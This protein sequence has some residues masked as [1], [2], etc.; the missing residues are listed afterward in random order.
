ITGTS[1]QTVSYGDSGTAVTAVPETGY[2]FAG[3][4]DGSTVNPR[5]DTNV[6]GN[7]TVTA[8]FAI[9]TY[10]LTITSGNGSGVYLS[11]QLLAIAANVPAAGQIFDHWIGDTVI[12]ANSNLP[13][14]FAKMPDMNVAVTAT[15]KDPGS[16]PYMLTVNEGSGNGTYLPGAVVLVAADS[17]LE[18]QIFDQWTGDTANLVNINLPDTRLHMPSD[19]VV[20]TAVY[21]VLEDVPYTLTV[22]EGSGSGS[23][24]AG[25]V[26]PVAADPPL[27]GQIFDQWTGDTANLV[28]VNLSNTHL[29]MPSD[30]VEL[31]AT[32]REHGMDEYDLT[33]RDGSGGGS[34]LSGTAVNIEASVPVG[35]YFIQWLGQNAT[36]TDPY[37]V[38]TVIYMP[39]ANT[40]VMPEFAIQTY[41]LTYTAGSNGSITGISSQA[42]DYGGS[43]T[44]VTAVPETGYHFVQ[45][46][47]GSTANPRTDTNVTDNISVASNFGI[48][49]YDVLFSA[50]EGGHISGETAQVIEYSGNSISVEAIADTGYEFSGW[51]GD[52]DTM[53]NPLILEGVISDMSVTANFVVNFSPDNPALISPIGNTIIDPAIVTFYAGAFNDPEGDAHIESTWQIRRAGVINLLYSISSSADLMEHVPGNVFENGVQYE[54]RVGY[55]DGGSLLTSWSPW[56]TF[57][58]GV[59]VEDNNIPSIPPGF[60]MKD[61]Q[62]VSFIQWPSDYSF[63]N[64]LDSTT[65][66]GATLEDFKIGTYNPMTGGYEE[67]PELEIEPGRAYWMLARYGMNLA[68]DGVF[69][70]TEQDFKVNLMYNEE[71]EDGWNMI[72]APN[73]AYYSWG[74]VE[75]IETDADGN[76]IFGPMP[77]SMLADDNEYIDKRIW[78]WDDGGYTFDNSDSF[79]IAPYEG[80]WVKSKKKNIS[81][82]FPVSSQSGRLQFSSLV[83][84]GKAWIAAVFNHITPAC[85]ASGSDDSP[86]MPMGVSESGS[87]SSDSGCFI[88]VITEN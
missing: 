80:V 49:T 6:T 32:Y 64:V 74:D 12:L 37:A 31:T 55:M 50:A 65:D 8:A 61:Y 52:V 83:T 81:L 20:L 26:V 2:H 75:I 72:G 15:Y 18:G 33:V 27:E 4:S 78:R 10:T 28:N 5:T 77:I 40:T 84:Q 45:W 51:S 29:Y 42:V 60:R 62:L 36:I 14:T 38:A 85:E 69:V 3:W 71:S 53:D 30:N 66:P 82:V 58:S 87:S 7:I 16:E 35:K 59:T 11:N 47:D 34:Y 22:N 41:T 17:P 70:S 76:I 88:Q 79:V 57:I 48:N 43:G 24:L 56:G 86:P 9:N 54:W 39:S 46:N 44:Q 68:M 19:D 67:Y 13:N 23:Y 21:K 63:L 73:G 1:P 25:V